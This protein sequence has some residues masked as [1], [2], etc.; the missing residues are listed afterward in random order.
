MTC[1]FGRAPRS[2][3]SDIR[4]HISGV[5]TKL[6]SEWGSQFKTRLDAVDAFVTGLK[7]PLGELLAAQPY[8]VAGDALLMTMLD[9]LV[10]HRARKGAS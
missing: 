9:G 8:F 10:R 4:T 7:E 2:L 6:E 3:A 1:A 5:K